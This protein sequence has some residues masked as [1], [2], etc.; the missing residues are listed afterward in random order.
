[1]LEVQI[2]AEAGG[3]TVYV[4]L[5][6]VW[7]NSISCCVRSKNGALPYQKP[8]CFGHG[9]AVYLL[10]TLFRRRLKQIS[11]GLCKLL[12]DEQSVVYLE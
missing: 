9:M 7:K 1:M 12:I 3:L 5:R 2:H 6:H 4:P 10:V 8:L 11:S